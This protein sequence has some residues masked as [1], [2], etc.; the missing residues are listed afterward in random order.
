MASD[1]PADSA[2]AVWARVAEYRCKLADALEALTPEQLESA[3][4]CSGWRVRDVL[5]HLVHIA[6]ASQLSMARD[7]IRHPLRPDSA[8]DLIA[9]QLGE[10]P[11][12]TLAQR[13]RD[14]RHGRFHVLGFPPAVELGDVMVHGNDTLRALDL[15]FAVHPY[16]AVLVLKTYRRVGGLAFHARPHRTVTLVAT[17]IQWSCG[18]GPVVTGRAI[19]LLMLVANRRQVIESLSG[20]GVAGVAV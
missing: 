20:P 13:L 8:L 9:R 1:A 17:D 7:V 12:P 16:E 2:P 10:E 6:E 11:V 14:A 18:T 15:E 19:D 5:G 3:S 4:W